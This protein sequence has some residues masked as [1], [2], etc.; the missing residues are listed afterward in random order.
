MHWLAAWG[1]LPIDFGVSIGS[2]E[3]VTQRTIIKNNLSG[4]HIRILFSNKYGKKP[5]TLNRVT[6]GQYEESDECVTRIISVTSDKKEYYDKEKCRKRAEKHF[7]K[8]DRYQDYLQ[9]FKTLVK[10]S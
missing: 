6:A 2:L 8:N 9:L 3:N 7:D 10:E 4:N 5:L 1:Y